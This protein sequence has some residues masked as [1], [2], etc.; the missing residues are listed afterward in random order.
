M[1]YIL[2]DGSYYVNYNGCWVCGGDY[3]NN[4]GGS[5]NTLMIGYEILRNAPHYRYENDIHYYLKDD[6]DYYYYS[7]GKRVLL[8][9]KA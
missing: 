4:N 9:I 6:V 7:N 1:Y 2:S 8:N 3:N 5:N